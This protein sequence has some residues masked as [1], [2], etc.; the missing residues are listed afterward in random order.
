MLRVFCFAFGIVVSGWVLLTDV[1]RA[2]DAAC[3][4]RGS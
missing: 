2:K 3:P 4:P 1:M